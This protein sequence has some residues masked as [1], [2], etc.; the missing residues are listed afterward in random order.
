MSL[1]LKRILLAA[2][3][4]AALVATPASAR[5]GRCLGG[6]TG[7]RCHLWTGKVTR[8]NDGDTMHVDIAGDGRKRSLSVR[9]INVQAMEQ[10]VYS[11]H[12]ERRRGECHALEAT[13][14]LERLIR[15]GHRRV[16]LA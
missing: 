4:L 1:A 7:P 5:G 11:K 3:V 6:K 2:L 8:V 16:R 15:A 9:F 14:R 13:A 12:P 10:S